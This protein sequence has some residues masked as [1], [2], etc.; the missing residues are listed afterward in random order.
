M[1]P[2]PKAESQPG[3]TAAPM[4]E[5]EQGSRPIEPRVGETQE[6]APGSMEHRP[7]G[8]SSAVSAPKA[9]VAPLGTRSATSAAP[10][11][12][13]ASSGPLPRARLV[14]PSNFPFCF[15]LSFY[16]KVVFC[17]CQPE[18][19]GTVSQAGAPEGD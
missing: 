1:T 15:S 16:L 4:T 11:G 7:K 2:T 3:V 6:A 17:V 12:T 18:V 13:S 8:Q 9:L 19:E 10:R 5:K 14:S